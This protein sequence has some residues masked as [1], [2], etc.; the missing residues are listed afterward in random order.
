MPFIGPF[1][2]KLKH[3]QQHFLSVSCTVLDEN[4]RNSLIADTGS[5]ENCMDMVFTFT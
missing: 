1:F 5:W 3:D 4:L 2:M